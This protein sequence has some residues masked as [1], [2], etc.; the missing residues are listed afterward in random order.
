MKERPNPYEMQLPQADGVVSA[1]E[2]RTSEPREPSRF[3]KSVKFVLGL[4]L[5]AAVAGGISLVQSLSQPG[6]KPDLV[7]M[8]PTSHYNIEYRL[9]G[10][11]R[12]E[13]SEH[14]G[15]GTGY[16]LIDTR[17]SAVVEILSYSSPL[18]YPTAAKH[19][20][21]SLDGS[22]GQWDRA[23]QRQVSNREE[24]VSGTVRV[25]DSG[26][27][28]ERL[29]VFIRELPD[30]KYLE[31]RASVLESEL[32]VLEPALHAILDSVRVR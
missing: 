22:T 10:N 27:P 9:P 18:A 13:K 32:H 11:W 25:K 3:G 31:I 19:V 12:T 4:V 24:W 1:D 2:T 6:V 8:H 23:D 21:I 30:G 17:Q 14:W 20:R 15:A 28:W 7:N 29:I 16:R 5:A 26:S